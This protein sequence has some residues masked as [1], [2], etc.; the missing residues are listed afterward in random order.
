MKGIVS[1]FST[2]IQGDWSSLPSV[3][4]SQLLWVVLD[5]AA[6]ESPW[7]WGSIAG[8]DLCQVGC[9]GRIGAA[10]V[11]AGFLASCFPTA[12]Q[13]SNMLWVHGWWAWH[14]NLGH[15]TWRWLRI[16]RKTEQSQGDPTAS[17]C[18]G[19][20]WSKPARLCRLGSRGSDASDWYLPLPS[21]H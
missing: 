17:P 4:L 3:Q 8:W 2:G 13:G 7:S 21:N 6:G 20:G 5:R 1:N 18:T 12:Q 15:L 11:L 9:P 16:A 14:T 19:L 10:S